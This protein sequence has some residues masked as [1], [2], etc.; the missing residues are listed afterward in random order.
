M[1]GFMPQF[2]VRAKIFCQRVEALHTFFARKFDEIE[3]KMFDKNIPALEKELSLFL[4]SAKSMREDLER[5]LK[6]L[7]KIAKS[8]EDYESI[9]PLKEISVIQ[10]TF[11]SRYYNGYVKRVNAQID[12]FNEKIAAFLDYYFNQ[13][14]ACKQDWFSIKKRLDSEFDIFLKTISE[15]YE[16]VYSLR[17]TFLQDILAANKKYNHNLDLAAQ[18]AMIDDLKDIV[19]ILRKHRACFIDVYKKEEYAKRMHEHQK[20]I[21]KFEKEI[22]HILIAINRNKHITISEMC[23]NEKNKYLKKILN[24]YCELQENIKIDEIAIKAEIGALK[25][26][27]SYLN[28][29]M[30]IFPNLTI[31]STKIQKR[32]ENALKMGWEN[33]IAN[34]LDAAYDCLML[35]PIIPQKPHS[36]MDKNIYEERFKQK[37]ETL[38]RKDAIFQILNNMWKKLPWNGYWKKFEKAASDRQFRQE[39]AVLNQM[40]QDSRESFEQLFPKT[41]AKPYFSSGPVSMLEEARK[42]SSQLP[43]ERKK[44]Q[45]KPV[46][47]YQP[48]PLPNPPTLNACHLLLSCLCFG[49]GGLLYLGFYAYRYYQYRKSYNQNCFFRKKLEQEEKSQPHNN[50]ICHA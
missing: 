27:Y 42:E 29:D 2:Q 46:P 36:A 33:A 37:I 26:E 3:E 30:P 9:I 24:K 5:E 47:P 13:K 21:T 34:D 35:D 8:K 1:G 15:D 16:P 23:I 12:L 38:E 45:R 40:D 14:F 48:T 50:L 44:C 6:A 11:I 49:I 31:D 32:F 20:N 19:N 18:I 10:S 4:S 41:F 25:I 39:S 7:K 17:E 22:T 43:R 28:L